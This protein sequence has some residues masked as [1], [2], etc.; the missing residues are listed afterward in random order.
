MRQEK[1]FNMQQESISSND[2]YTPAWIFEAMAVEFNLD[3]ASP[4][5]G[6]N[7]IPAHHYYTML[8]DGLSQDWFGRVW[9]NPPFKGI[10]PWVKKFIDHANGIALL[11]LEKG[12]YTD[13]I[14]N[15]ADAH[16]ILPAYLKFETKFSKHSDIRPVCLL[17]AIGESN[18]EAIGR[19]GRLYK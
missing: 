14:N 16:V 2:Y 10:T 11:P 9:M 18:V 3:V 5:G 19:V 13:L 12:K 15:A 8:D 6:I 17:H 1:L 7:W 4:P